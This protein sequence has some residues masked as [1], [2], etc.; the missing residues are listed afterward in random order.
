MADK[1]AADP[2]AFVKDLLAGGVAGQYM[3]L[4]Y[5]HFDRQLPGVIHVI[6]LQVTRQIATASASGV[7]FGKVQGDIP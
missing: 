3:L 6:L 4:S 7:C 2:F 5:P 1:K